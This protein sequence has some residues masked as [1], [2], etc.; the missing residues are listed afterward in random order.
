MATQALAPDRPA[1]VGKFHAGRVVTIATGHAIHDT[2][3]AFLPPLLPA[4]KE[5]LLLSHT[6]LGLLTVFLSA[7]SLVQPV[8]GYLGDRV[9]LRP[10]VI[11][12][13]AVA[14]VTMSLLGVAPGYAALALLL[15]IAG[16]NSANLH[17]VA[18]VMA[19]RL[20]GNS[21]GRGMG[22]WMVGGELGRTLGPLIVVTA[23]AHLG[24]Q[25]TPWLMALG[26]LASLLVYVGLRGV[27]I[28][29]PKDGDR[30]AS[31]QA[32]RSMGPFLA[33]LAA[34]L[35]VRALM[36]G[37]LTTYLPVF[38]SEEGAT[39]WHAG[40]ALSVLQAAGVVGAL[41]GG[42]LSDRLGRRL[43]LLLSLLLTPVFMFA[44]LAAKGWGQFLLLPALGLTSLSTTPAIMALVQES[45]P[46]SRSLANGVYMALSFLIQSG[47]V[48]VLGAVG[49]QFGL[50]LAFTVSAAV[51][52]LGLPFLF[53]FPKRRSNDGV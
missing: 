29:I 48:L 49:D 42:A 13:P 23:V 51:P 10:L 45:F 25:G 19:G 35:A 33:P 36:I 47:A 20:S 14:G 46:H 5:S 34:I 32:L 21:L 15:I 1:T 50:R 12:A 30:P 17:A 22:F 3:T 28:H 43:I 53:L 52:L 18:P 2:Y 7:P 38:L 37:A 39:L 31:W 24:L 8:L 41:L 40:A 4:F 27:P 44:F 26:F 16:L 11:L 9:D 6:Q